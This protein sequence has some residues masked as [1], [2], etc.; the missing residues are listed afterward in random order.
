MASQKDLT[1]LTYMLSK[2]EVLG[3]VRACARDTVRSLLEDRIVTPSVVPEF[4]QCGEPLAGKHC[5]G[6][7]KG[8]VL[9]NSK[10]GHTCHTVLPTLVRKVVQWTSQ[11]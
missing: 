7:Q 11:G 9:A 10:L 2:V 3:S 8:V 5:V 6:W 4:L 1:A